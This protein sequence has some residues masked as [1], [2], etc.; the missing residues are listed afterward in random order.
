MLLQWWC[1]LESYAKR[2]T[3][4]DRFITVSEI[5]QQFVSGVYLESYP[6]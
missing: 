6:E 5:C 3:S 2:I 4:D 1:Y